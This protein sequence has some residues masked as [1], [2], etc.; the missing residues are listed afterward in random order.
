MMQLGVLLCLLSCLSPA[1]GEV[2]ETQGVPVQLFDERGRNDRLDVNYVGQEFLVERDR[3]VVPGAW[4]WSVSV[5]FL[6]PG[7]GGAGD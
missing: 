7:G 1:Y 6:R 5:G 4:P 3:R 2:V